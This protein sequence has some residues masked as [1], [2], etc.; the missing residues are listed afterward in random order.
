MIWLTAAWALT[1]AP[2][3]VKDRPLPLFDSALLVSVKGASEVPTCE[4]ARDAVLARALEEG[5]K[6][7]HTEVIGIYAKD[8]SAAPIT[9]LTCKQTGIPDAPSGATASAAVLLVRPGKD[10]PSTATSRQAQLVGLLTAVHQT[11]V[12]ELGLVKEDGKIWV[13][14]GIRVHE[15]VLSPSLDLNGRAVDVLQAEVVPWVSRWSPLSG[16]VPE[17]AGAI[18]AVDTKS[19]GEKGKRKER[20]RY[21]VDAVNAAAFTVGRLADPDWTAT[22]IVTVDENPKKPNPQRVNLDV[23][24]AAGSVSTGGDRTI[25]GDIDDL[26][27]E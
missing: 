24:G 9:S 18:I 20:F 4:A 16:Q 21:V 26:E 10:F 25:S 12:E 11:P 19:E 22:L 1:P 23:M 5:A 8:L 27:D 15:P 13:D 3:D 14:A 2:L 7:G 17:V 6:T